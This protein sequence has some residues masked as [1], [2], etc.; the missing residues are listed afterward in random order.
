MERANGGAFT[1]ALHHC[2]IKYDNVRASLI[3]TKTT[4]GLES[5]FL[6]PG[7]DLVQDSVVC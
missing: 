6:S 2:G 7:T 1:D 5:L 4:M 3:K